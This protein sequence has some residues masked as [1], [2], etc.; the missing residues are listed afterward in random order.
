MLFMAWN[1]SAMKQ[2]ERWLSPELVKFLVV[3]GISYLVNQAALV[4]MYEWIFAGVTRARHTS[5]GTV[6]LALLVSSIVAVE[7]AII[8]RFLLNDGWTFRH[9]REKP[10]VHRFVQSNFGS[11]GSPLIAL[12]AVNILTPVF[13]INYLVSNSIGIVLGMAWNWGWSTR[14]VWRPLEEPTSPHRP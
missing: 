6:N 5:L 8:A 1:R 10:F 11:F 4:L 9:R 3:G 12:C 13:G 2:L 7:I 14:V